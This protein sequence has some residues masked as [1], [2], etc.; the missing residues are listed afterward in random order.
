MLLPSDVSRDRVDRPPA[1]LLATLA[2]THAVGDGEQQ[3]A[4]APSE[5]QPAL[6]RYAGLLD[7]DDSPRSRD[8]VL[9]L[10]LLP[11]FPNIRGTGDIDPRV[12]ED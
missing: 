2:A 6:D 1:R 9:V 5:P 3:R 4:R 11:A 8:K 10:V 7:L 12:L